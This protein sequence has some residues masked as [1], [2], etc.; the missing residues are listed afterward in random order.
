M[1]LWKS[2]PGG[3]LSETKDGGRTQGQ[4]SDIDR[5]NVTVRFLPGNEKSTKAV[6]ERHLFLCEKFIDKIMIIDIMITIRA[7]YYIN[8]LKGCTM[9]AGGTC[10]R[11]Y[12]PC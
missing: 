10:R 1:A 11:E 5:K 6:I 7:I 8:V 3:I 4:V 12:Y 9:E 2:F